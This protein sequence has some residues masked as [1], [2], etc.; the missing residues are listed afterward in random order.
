V[1]N[2]VEV[3]SLA[4]TLLG[5]V[6]FMSNIRQWAYG[7]KAAGVV[8]QP[9]GNRKTAIVHEADIASVVAHILTSEGHSG[10]TYSITGPE[11]LTRRDLTRITGEAIGREIQFIELTPEE[12]Q[13]EWTAAGIPSDIVQFL[14]WA[15]GNTPAQGYPVTSTVE[16]IT[17]KPPRTFAQWASEHAA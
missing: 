4:W 1:E 14:L 11:V 6:E 5:P 7:I 8:R 9:F 10:K 2:A 15:Y 17:G 3:S 16:Q 13:A 12:A